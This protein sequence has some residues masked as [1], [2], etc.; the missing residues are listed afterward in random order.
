MNNPNNNNNNRNGRPN[1]S[2]FIP[3]LLV[4]VFLGLMLFS[5]PNQRNSSTTSVD[6]VKLNAILDS[7]VQIKDAKITV[8]YNTITVSGKYT[9]NNT[10]YAF[11]SVGSALPSI[12]SSTFTN[13]PW[14]AA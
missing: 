6:Y 5:S 9:D 8:D 12:V 4:A 13:S 2:N 14:S 1:L 11:T 10:E 3:Y 7:N